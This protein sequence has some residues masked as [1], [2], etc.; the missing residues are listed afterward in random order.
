MTEKK[1]A[2]IVAVIIGI[3]LMGSAAVCLFFQKKEED[4]TATIHLNGEKIETIDLSK[5]K[6]PY[7]KEIQCPQGGSNVIEVR[8]NAIGIIEAD[9]PDKLCQKQGFL[10]QTALPIVC[11]PHRLVI[12]VVRTK[13]GSDAA[14]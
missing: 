9:C 5:V 4:L 12:E 6:E 10:D 8:H 1:K 11:L 13:T 14:R 3:V 7:Q 2:A